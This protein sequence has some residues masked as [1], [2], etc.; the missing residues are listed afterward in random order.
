MFWGFLTQPYVL[1]NQPVLRH[2]RSSIAF[3]KDLTPVGGS[4]KLSLSR[5]TFT[6]TEI[7]RAFDPV[8]H[9]PLLVLRL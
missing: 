4:R 7:G 5:F 3:T 1:Y 9:V 2:Q 8:L 6:S